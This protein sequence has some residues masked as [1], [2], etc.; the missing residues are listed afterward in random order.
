MYVG[1]LECNATLFE[2]D[3]GHDLKKTKKKTCTPSGQLLN[4]K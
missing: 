3:E 2:D 4:V 1:S